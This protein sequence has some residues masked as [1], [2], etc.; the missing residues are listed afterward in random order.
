MLY[1]IELRALTR[2]CALNHPAP[3]AETANLVGVEG[4]EPPTSCSQSRRATRLRYTPEYA[5]TG[6]AQNTS[7]TLFASCNQG[8]IPLNKKGA[9]APIA[10]Y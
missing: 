1:P 10:K 2:N 6:D 5:G 4:F 8:A 3:T 9:E 7:G